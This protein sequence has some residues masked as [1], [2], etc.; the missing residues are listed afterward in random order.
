MTRIIE[1][2]QIFGHPE[3]QRFLTLMRN[4]AAFS[5]LEVLTYCLLD[6]HAHVPSQAERSAADRDSLL[7]VLGNSVIVR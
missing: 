5:G 4:L 1:R 2:R 6:N 7:A 3:K